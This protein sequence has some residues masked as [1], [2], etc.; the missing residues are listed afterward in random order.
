MPRPEHVRE[1]RSELPTPEELEHRKNE[2]WQLVAVE[3]QRETSAEP[4]TLEPQVPF[5]LRLQP[6]TAAIEENPVEREALALMLELITADE[7]SL[8]QVAAELNRRGF[9]TRRGSKWSEVAVF[10]ML[11]RLVETAP[12]IY[13]SAEWSA[14]KGRALKSA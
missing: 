1:T 2:G 4:P 13:A 7:T 3:W 10:N 12:R 8:S 5:G 6:S 9:R 11:P 14:R